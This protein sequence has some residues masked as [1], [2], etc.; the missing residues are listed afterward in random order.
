MPQDIPFIIIHEINFAHRMGELVWGEAVDEAYMLHAPLLSLT[1][2]SNA[3]AASCAARLSG[4]KHRS[5]RFNQFS[6]QL[7]SSTATCLSAGV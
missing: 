6:P 7:C 5:H 2:G 1:S 4:N 3:R